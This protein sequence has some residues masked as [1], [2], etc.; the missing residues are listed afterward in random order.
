MPWGERERGIAARDLKQNC[1]K[2]VTT[3]EGGEKKSGKWTSS[4]VYKSLSWDLS[5]I[6][7]SLS[8]SSTKLFFK[9]LRLFVLAAER[10]FSFNCL[11]FMKWDLN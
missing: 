7:V 4:L 10:V 2:I 3:N 5:Q 11:S 6:Y 8:C 1:D 9:L